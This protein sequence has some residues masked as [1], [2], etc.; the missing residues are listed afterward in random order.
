MKPALQNLR[1]R[2]EC[3]CDLI[4]LGVGFQEF[5]QEVG[6]V[7]AEFAVVG[8]EGGVEVGVDVEF[9]DDFFVS[10]DGDYDFG[11]GFEG[12]G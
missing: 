11:F 6:G 12:T 8:A 3:L 10:E 2:Q 5:A 1:A 9:A 7:F 4:W